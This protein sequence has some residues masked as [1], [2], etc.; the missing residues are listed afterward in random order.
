MTA[1]SLHAPSP[2]APVLLRE[3]SDGIAI[4]TLNRPSA[5]CERSQNEF[6]LCAVAVS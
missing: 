4:L 5:L 6:C 2:P 1:Q 3:T